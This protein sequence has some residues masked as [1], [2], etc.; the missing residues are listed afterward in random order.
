MPRGAVEN[1]DNLSVVL[2]CWLT[3]VAEDVA[4][5]GVQRCDLRARLR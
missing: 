5:A 2:T 3:S 1:G 4:A